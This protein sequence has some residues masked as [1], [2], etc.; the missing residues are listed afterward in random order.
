MLE[1]QMTP[2]SYFVVQLLSQ[3]ASIEI[4]YPFIVGMQFSCIP[5]FLFSSAPQLYAI[6]LGSC[7]QVAL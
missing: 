2:Q 7:I 6:V 1:C 3:L 4:R 5:R